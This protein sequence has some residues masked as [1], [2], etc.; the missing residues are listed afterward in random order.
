MIHYKGDQRTLYK[1]CQRFVDELPIE[2]K[3][4]PPVLFLLYCVHARILP[5]LG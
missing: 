4:T 1:D 5:R 3:V 2:D